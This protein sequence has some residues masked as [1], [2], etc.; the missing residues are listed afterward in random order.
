M[1]LSRLDRE[2][3]LIVICW[4][5][6]I[7]I[8]LC[9]HLHEHL[10]PSIFCFHFHSFCSL[11]YC[12]TLNVSSVIELVDWVGTSSYLSKS[13]S[14]P[15]GFLQPCVSYAALVTSALYVVCVLV[16]TYLHTLN[17]AAS[18]FVSDSMYHTWS[19]VNLGG[20]KYKG[21]LHLC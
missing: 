15:L 3:V 21:V 8:F 18:S 16:C 11:S 10:R 6:N 2:T 14:Y 1:L 5:H 12:S 19:M 4:C 9:C 7:G 20:L 17:L 13:F